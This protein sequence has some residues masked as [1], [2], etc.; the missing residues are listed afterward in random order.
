LHLPRRAAILQLRRPRAG[1]APNVLRPLFDIALARPGDYGAF[2]TSA[3]WLDVNY[4]AVLHSLLNDGLH[5]LAIHILAPQLQPF[6]DAITTGAITCFRMGDEPPQMRIRRITEIADLGD[7]ADTAGR[8]V[9][10][11]TLRRARQRSACRPTLCGCWRRIG[12]V[13]PRRSRPTSLGARWRSWVGFWLVVTMASRAG[14]R[15]GVAGETWI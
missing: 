5:G 6:A 14:R 13:R 2:I 15:Y 7:P 4:G 3:E 1:A 10:R 9:S 8:P 12:A 11:T